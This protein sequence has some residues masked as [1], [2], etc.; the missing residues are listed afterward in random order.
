MSTVLARTADVPTI[1]APKTRPHLFVRALH[2]FLK[3][4]VPEDRHAVTSRQR[5][6]S[7]EIYRFPMF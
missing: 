4:M 3:A 5:D 2:R 7:P 6:P 1:T